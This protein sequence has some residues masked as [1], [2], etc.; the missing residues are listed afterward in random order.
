MNLPIADWIRAVNLQLSAPVVT[1]ISIGVALLVVTVVLI[2]IYRRRFQASGGLPLQETA[3]PI[4]EQLLPHLLDRAN[5]TAAARLYQPVGLWTGRLILPPPDRRDPDGAVLF[6]VHNAD[7]SYEHLQDQI[8]SLKW[9]RNPQVQEWVRAVCVDVRFT[10]KAQFGQKLGNVL[11]ERLNKLNN[12]GPLESLAGARPQDDAIVELHNPVVDDRSGEPALIIGREPVQITGRLVALVTIIQRITNTTKDE[13]R[14]KAKGGGTWESQDTLTASDRF[15]VRHFNKITSQFDGPFDMIRIPQVGQ[16]YRGIYPSTN[17]YIEKSPLNATGWY[18]Y[19]EK[20]ARGIFVTQA[21]EPRAVMRLNPDDTITGSKQALTYLKKE[22]W[23]NTPSKKGTVSTVLLAPTE[24]NASEAVS[25]WQPG[26]T[27]IVI[28]LFGGIGGKKRDPA[29]LGLVPGHFA[30]GIATVV[31]DPLSGDLRFDIEYRQVYAHNPQGI[32]SGTIK[33]FSYM[34]DLQR[35]WLGTRPLS[36]I[37]V[38]FAPITVDFDFDGI[39]VSPMG[40]FS[41]QLGIMCARYR[42]GDGTGASLVTPEAS[43]VQDS[44]QA[45][46]ITIKRIEAA[47]ASNPRI[48]DWLQRHPRDPQTQ[49]FKQLVDLATRLE[50]NLVPFGIVQPDWRRNVKRVAATCEPETVM[51][52]LVK[53]IATWRTMLPRRTHDEIA[54]ILLQQG[55]ALWV[56]RTNQVGGFDPEIEPAAPTAL[57]GHRIR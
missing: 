13:K 49:Q 7:P 8:V 23:K 10:R 39:K 1:G 24:E 18:I 32:I 27:A 48:Q 35:G 54:T 14:K 56:L 30:Y 57:F 4:S 26:E 16:N 11:P 20:D 44:N 9:S 46:Y 41:Q 19:G 38:K 17:R 22:N 34:G 21:I 15:L 45:L 12:V 40:E 36:D 33:W 28:H 55:A 5:Q 53:A 51:G 52:T 2:P 37:L 50:K 42:T 47:I 6:E 29:P 43:C 3:P 31:R 25:R